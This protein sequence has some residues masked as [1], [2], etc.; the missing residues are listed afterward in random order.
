LLEGVNDFLACMMHTYKIIGP[1][2]THLSR[3]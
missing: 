3:K 2:K 1:P